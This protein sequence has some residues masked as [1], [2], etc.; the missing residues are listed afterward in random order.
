M[1][2]YYEEVGGIRREIPSGALRGDIRVFGYISGI[3]REGESRDETRYEAF[4]IGN[5][6]TIE[7]WG[8]IRREA[9]DRALSIID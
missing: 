7:E 2:F 5:P 4:L 9:I 8:T 3:Y 1:R 6:E